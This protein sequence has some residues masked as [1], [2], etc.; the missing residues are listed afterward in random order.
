MTPE[1]ILQ[2]A[3]IGPRRRVVTHLV[4]VERPWHY[5]LKSGEEARYLR[6]GGGMAVHFGSGVDRLRLE[7]MC[8]KITGRL[9]P[10]RDGNTEHHSSRVLKKADCMECKVALDHALEVAGVNPNKHGTLE[11]PRTPTHSGSHR[12][13]LR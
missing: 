8:I 1:E 11:V 7:A 6:L 4:S 5:T 3:F 2:E 12:P 13:G 9:L 10:Y